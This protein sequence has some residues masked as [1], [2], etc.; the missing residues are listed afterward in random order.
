MKRAVAATLFAP[1]LLELPVLL[2]GSE[3]DVPPLKVKQLC[4]QVM[5]GPSYYVPNASVELRRERNS[6]TLVSQTV[7][8]EGKFFFREVKKGQYWLY[9]RIAEGPPPIQ[10][11]YRVRL[12]KE[13]RA[14]SCEQEIEVS[15]CGLEMHCNWI[16]LRKKTD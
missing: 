11:V 4:G 6:G 9:V 2:I 1:L 12:T 5:A 8:A 15:V 10:K 3:I 14:A 16:K 7:D 13:S